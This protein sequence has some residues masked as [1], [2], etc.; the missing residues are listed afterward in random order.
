MSKIKVLAG[1][2]SFWSLQ[3][4]SVS[5]P[6]PTSKGHLHFPSTFKVPPPASGSMVT[7]PFSVFD[8]PAS[9]LQDP[10]DYVDPLDD[11]R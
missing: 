5:L 8:P 9:L 1:L 6:F 7:S 10:C 3:G 2:H 4:K 11:P